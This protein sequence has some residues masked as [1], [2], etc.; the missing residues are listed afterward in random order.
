M[1]KTNLLNKQL[2]EETTRN[3]FDG[4]FRGERVVSGMVWRKKREE[5]ES[6]ERRRIHQLFNKFSHL[7]ESDN[8]TPT[9]SKLTADMRD[10]VASGSPCYSLRTR[11]EVF[12]N[13]FQRSLRGDFMSS[14]ST[15]DA[16]ELRRQ[17]LGCRRRS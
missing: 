6:H 14:R 9:P 5:E 17:G 4:E 15:A 12:L 1:G 2:L 7:P 11:Y 8:A 10:R 16:I 13:P 3:G